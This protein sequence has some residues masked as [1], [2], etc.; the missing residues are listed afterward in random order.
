LTVLKRQP[1]TVWLNAVSSV[2]LQ[3]TLRHVDRG[4]LNFFEGRARYPTYHKRRGAQSATFTSNAFDWNP[5]T[6]AL[7]LAKL[8]GPLRI[9]WTRAFTTTPTSVTVTLDTTG[10]YVVSFA[11]EEAVQPLPTTASEVGVDLGLTHLAALSTGEKVPN[12][13]YLRRVERRLAHAQRTLSR[14]RKGSRNRA[15]ARCKVA[16][17]HARIADQRRDGHHK[18]TTR[19]IRENQAVCVESLAVKNMVRNRKLAKAISDAGWGEIR[20]QLTYKAAWY[21]RTL[22]TIDRWFPSSKTCSTCGHVLDSLSP[23]VRE[24]TCPACGMVHDRD[25]NAAQNILA[26]GRTASACGG[27]VRPEMVSPTLA[28]S[29]EAGIPWL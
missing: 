1:E 26:V 6:R 25:I 22:V 5:Q 24:W 28:R 21:G 10:R 9:R 12:A 8:D 15:K 16:R 14:K 29:R 17:L 2:P 13:K 18:L 4:Y 11:T 19:I 7:T 20:R 27:M 23:D 3:Q